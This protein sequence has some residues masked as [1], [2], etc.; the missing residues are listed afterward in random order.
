MPLPTVANR[1]HSNLYLMSKPKNRCVT[2]GLVHYVRRRSNYRYQ[3]CNGVI[4]YNFTDKSQALT[5]LL[6]IVREQHD[7]QTT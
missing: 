5:C 6:C 3:A 1:H 7:H 2:N 4:V